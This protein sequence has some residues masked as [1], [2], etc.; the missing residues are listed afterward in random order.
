MI[1]SQFSV[2]LFAWSS[3]LFTLYLMMWIRRSILANVIRVNL[4]SE[5]GGKL[6]ASVYQIF[7][8]I[9]KADTNER[10][11]SWFSI[12]SVLFGCDHI[13]SLSVALWSYFSLNIPGSI[14]PRIKNPR[15]LNVR[16]W[17]QFVIICQNLA[18]VWFRSFVRISLSIC[19][20][21][22]TVD[23]STLDVPIGV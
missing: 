2:C 6:F 12:I 1:F 19:K 22:P 11:H 10:F 9:R 4:Y 15:F 13:F 17:L 5:N 21:K 23:S 8:N 14:V 18:S 7:A 3:I 20:L 16:S